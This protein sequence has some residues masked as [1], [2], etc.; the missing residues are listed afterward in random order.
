MTTL[1]H[2]TDKPV[3]YAFC[4]VAQRGKLEIQALLL[5]LSLAKNVHCSYEIIA[6]VPTSY[7]VL[8]PVVQNLFV[9]LNVRF[10]EITNQISHD[11]PI[12]NKLSCLQKANRV[13]NAR[14]LLFLDTDMFCNLPFKGVPDIDRFDVGLRVAGFAKWKDESHWKDESKAISFKGFGYTRPA[15]HV[16]RDSAKSRKN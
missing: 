12:G 14:Y 4:F 5:A 8:D 6:A 2:I 10:V 3:E 16:E 15:L 1:E 9:E 11:Y 13:T 7:G